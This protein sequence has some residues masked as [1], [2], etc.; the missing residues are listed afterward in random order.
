MCFADRGERYK[1]GYSGLHWAAWE[2]HEDVVRN[3]SSKYGAGVRL[4]SSICFFLSFSVCILSSCCLV[5]GGM[6][7]EQSR[8]SAGLK[9]ANSQREHVLCDVF[10][11]GFFVEALLTCERRR[12]LGGARCER[13]DGALDCN[14]MGACQGGAGSARSGGGS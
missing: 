10:F 5:L 12:R 13:K 3:L 1:A 4:F 8:L 14:T 6:S 9:P 11:F 2:G 7:C